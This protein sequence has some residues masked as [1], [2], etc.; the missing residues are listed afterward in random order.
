VIAIQNYNLLFAIKAS[1][2]PSYINPLLVDENVRFGG[3]PLDINWGWYAPSQE[4]I[5]GGYKGWWHTGGFYN[6]I[7]SI[8]ETEFKKIKEVY[9]RNLN[10]C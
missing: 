1:K 9:F 7:S 8:I 6:N 3:C 10:K 5:P 2:N 4:G